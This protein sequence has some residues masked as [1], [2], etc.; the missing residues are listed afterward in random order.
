VPERDLARESDGS[1]ARAKQ[2]ADAETKRL[3]QELAGELVEILTSPGKL[4]R[5]EGEGLPGDER[6][7]VNQVQDVLRSEFLKHATRK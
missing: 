4:R 3:R 1:L 5:D 2:R 7:Y 6:E